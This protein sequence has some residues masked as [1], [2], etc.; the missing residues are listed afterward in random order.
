MADKLYIPGKIKVGFRD[1]DGTYTGKLAYVI[2][3]DHKGILRKEKSWESWRD[4]K[5]APVEFSNEPTEGFVLNKGVGGVRHS[6]VGMS[7]MSILE[8]MTHEISSLRSLSPIYYSYYVSVIATRVKGLMVSLCMLGT[9]PNLCSCL[10]VLRI[11]RT[12][13]NLLPYRVRR[14]RHVN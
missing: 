14:L 13:L 11:I 6:W 12:R 9:V 10:S 1:R 8:S 4:E 3:Y 2:Y 5:I 7:V